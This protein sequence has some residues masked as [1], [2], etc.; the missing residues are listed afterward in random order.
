MN[1]DIKYFDDKEFLTTFVK[2]LRFAF[3]NN[4][5]KVDLLRC[6][7]ALGKSYETILTL[8]DLFEEVSFIKI[9]ERNENFYR[10][11]LFEINELSS[12]L[13]SEKYAEVKTLV[14]ECEIFQKKL[15]ECDL[16]TLELV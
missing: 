8:L 5:G 16:A 12:V 13:H 14:N 4:S 7:S 10:I 6:S 15:L 11:E 2:M 9:L 3:N 1:Y